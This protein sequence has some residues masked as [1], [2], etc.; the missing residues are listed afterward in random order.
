LFGDASEDSFSEITECCDGIGGGAYKP[1]V[2]EKP[3]SGIRAE[4]LG[5][6]S[7]SMPFMTEN[8]LDVAIPAREGGNYRTTR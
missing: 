3:D 5:I 8:Y 2:R 4:I 1:G 7:A 6:S